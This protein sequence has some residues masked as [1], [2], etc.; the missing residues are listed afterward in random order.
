MA[1]D[2]DA[3][4]WLEDLRNE[5][6][7]EAFIPESDKAVVIGPPEDDGS[8]PDLCIGLVDRPGPVDET[9]GATY[10]RPN[11]TI[12]VRSEPLRPRAAYNVIMAVFK[13]AARQANV[14]MGSTSF[15]R[16]DPMLAPGRLRLDSKNRTDYTCEFGV[17]LDEL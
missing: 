7:A 12:V 13:W 11:L 9:Y 15:V 8:I 5:I 10:P 17:W 16:L 1:V 4:V 2:V 14:T 6:I 3:P